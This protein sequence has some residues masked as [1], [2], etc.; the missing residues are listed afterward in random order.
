[1]SRGAVGRYNAAVVLAGHM[2][3]TV[4]GTTYEKAV[5]S[6]VLDPLRLDHTRFFTDELVGQPFAAS[7]NVVDGKAVLAPSLWPIPRSLHPTGG[8]IS[9]AREQLSY[10]RFHLGDGKGPDGKP[11]L[12]RASLEA[13]RS[14]PGPGGTLFVELDG[15]GVTFHLRPSAEGVRIVQHGGDW[16]GQHS[17][18]FFVPDR[19]FAFVILT[20]S[21]GGPKLTGEL[22]A[23]DWVLSRFA[24]LH[25]LPAVPRTLSDG[26][27]AAYVGDYTVSS[28]GADGQTV[29]TKGQITA[30]QGRLRIH[31]LGPDGTPLELPPGS[32]EILAFYRDDY[33]LP[34]DGD[35]KPI[36][37]RANFVRDAG[38][39][40]Q[41]FR[42]AGRLGRKAS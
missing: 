32:P 7:H 15:M 38:G 29:T 35:S 41:W 21:V 2:L 8:L 34:L 24:G 5:Q 12:T 25:N 20:N 39:Q 19:D 30:D 42:F 18:F 9:N 36:G 14:H 11:I 1:L 10:A 40:V 37:W 17:G 13:M 22:C 26:E 3:E 33:V 16:T 4:N 28:I 27:L 31:T 6:L 23:D